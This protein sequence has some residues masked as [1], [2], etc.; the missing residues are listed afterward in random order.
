MDMTH[1]RS[2]EERARQRAGELYANELELNRAIA[3]AIRAGNSSEVRALRR[4]RRELRD[5]MEDHHATSAAVLEEAL[6]G[7]LQADLPSLE[8]LLGT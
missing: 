6:R 3:Q 7:G 8:A 2:I 4:A 1:A 5:I